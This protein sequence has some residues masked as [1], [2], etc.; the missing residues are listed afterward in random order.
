M[1]NTEVKFH[2]IKATDCKEFSPNGMFGG[3]CPNGKISVAL[4]S[5]RPPIPKEIVHTIEGLKLGPELTDKRIGKTDYVRVVQ[6]V[7]QIDVSVAKSFVEWLQERIKD[8][9]KAGG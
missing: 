9:E 5:E 8:A 7:I 4:Y 6:S 3:L 1:K 2:F